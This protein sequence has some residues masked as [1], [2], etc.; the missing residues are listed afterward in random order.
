LLPQTLKNNQPNL[1]HSQ[2]RDM[3]DSNDPLI[4]LA[5]T[6]HWELFEDSFAKYYSIEGRPAVEKRTLGHP[7]A[8]TLGQ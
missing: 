6:I 5:D 2:L 3:L 1:F 4:A 8:S 7:E